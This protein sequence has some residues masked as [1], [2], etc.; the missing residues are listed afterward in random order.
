MTTETTYADKKKL[1][2]IGALCT[3]LYIDKEAKKVM[4]AGFTNGRA[5]SS[6]YLLPAEAD[7]MINHLGRLL[8]KTND[9]VSQKMRRKIISM[10]HEL[11]W[12]LPGTS[13]ADMQRI[14][15][16]CCKYGQYK[17]EL[18]K[19]TYKELVNLVGQFENMYNYTLKN[20]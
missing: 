16:W 17:K 9:D 12:H 18:D 8:P 19:H 7:A 15:N 5:E 11:H 1:A 6:K 2:S 3:R 13:K 10:A 4:V 14:N 20:L